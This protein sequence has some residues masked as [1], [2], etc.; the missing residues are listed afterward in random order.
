[1]TG[2]SRNLGLKYLWAQQTGLDIAL[3]VIRQTS[4]KIFA[5]KS[6]LWASRRHHL[7]RRRQQPRRG[8][9]ACSIML[10]EL[11]GFNVIVNNAGVNKSGR[12]LTWNQQTSTGPAG[13]YRRRRLGRLEEMQ[14][15]KLQTSSRGQDYQCCVYCRT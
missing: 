1:M 11:G 4:L 3:V 12:S 6:K 14:R 2:A 15:K 8:V 9:Y 10:K 5:R 7:R 13:S